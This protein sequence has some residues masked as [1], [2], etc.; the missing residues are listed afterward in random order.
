MTFAE[1]MA[2]AGTS[3]DNVFHQL[4][5]SYPDAVHELSGATA[6][7]AKKAHLDW[8]IQESEVAYTADGG[9]TGR[10]FPGKR[11]F[12]RSD[13]QAPL[14]CVG[15]RHKPVQPEEMLNFYKEF[16]DRYGFKLA[17]AGEVNGG[18]K[19]WAIA[20]T[21]HELELVHGDKVRGS[22]MFMTACDGSMSTQGFFSSLRLRCLNQL[23]VLHKHLRNAAQRGGGLRLFRITHGAKFNMGRVE[24]DLEQMQLNWESFGRLTQALAEKRIT[25]EQAIDFF[26]KHFS[27]QGEA[28]AAP[29]ATEIADMRENA[30]LKNLVNIYECGE[31][32]EQITGTAWG[33]VNAVTR[34]LDH[35][36]GYR[37][38]NGRIN[39]AWIN[40]ARTKVAV[41]RDALETFAPK[42]LTS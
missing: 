23:P 41:Y 4:A 40:G 2:H 36:A 24:K 10:L 15:K 12:Y 21:P 13:T 39:M 19:L 27:T 32:Q 37:S 20:E 6:T 8:S 35:E 14:S 17:I 18:R 31:G 11:I 34:Y 28:T 25:K 9:Q 5:A 26:H 7:W 33:A 30:K 22:F 42:A 1:R 16:S 29:S 3:D 38:N